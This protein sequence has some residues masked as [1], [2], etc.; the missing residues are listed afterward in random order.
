MKSLFELYQMGLDQIKNVL[1][2]I[3]MRS[4]NMMKNSVIF[5]IS[6]EVNRG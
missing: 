2:N 5:F 6:Y 1:A 3:L 4:V